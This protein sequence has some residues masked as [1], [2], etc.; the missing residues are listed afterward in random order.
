[1]KRRLLQSMALTLGISSMVGFTQTA[2]AESV[3]YKIKKG[4][5]LYSIAQKYHTSVDAL[6]KLN[7]LRSNT[8]YVGSTLFIKKDSSYDAMK[9]S[10]SLKPKTGYS[11]DKEEPGKFILQYKKNGNYFA[12]IEVLD[13]K[14]KITDVKKNSITYLGSTGKVVEYSTKQGIPLYEHASFFLHAHNSKYQQNVIVKKVDG[15]LI[16]FTIHFE[17]KEGS[18]GITPQMIEMLQTIKVK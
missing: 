12:R 7:G 8:I 6:K 18:E 5:T 10:I 17:N 13:S 11:F 15:K 9:V 1:M 2:N 3:S 16:R 14:A 4:D